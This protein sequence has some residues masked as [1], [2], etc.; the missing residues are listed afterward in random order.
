MDAWRDHACRR[1][2]RLGLCEERERG[3]FHPNLKRTRPAGRSKE[4][5]APDCF[6]RSPG[7]SPQVFLDVEV[8]CLRRWLGSCAQGTLFVD[9]R[10]PQFVLPQSR[11]W[12]TCR[13]AK[14]AG[15]RCRVQAFGLSKQCFVIDRLRRF[16]RL[17]CRMPDGRS[18]LSSQWKPRTPTA[19]SLGLLNLPNLLVTCGSL[20]AVMVQCAKNCQV[21]QASA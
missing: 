17:R 12:S 19:I 8:G 18:K 1:R 11:G 2:D 5:R 15:S 16:W 4:K 10:W 9:P 7:L 20:D 21:L 6:C 3:R 13:K 14:T